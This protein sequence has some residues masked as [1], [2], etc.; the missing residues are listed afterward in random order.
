MTVRSIRIYVKAFRTNLQIKYI[1]S[2]ARTN[3]NYNSGLSITNFNYVRK[4]SDNLV[5]LFRG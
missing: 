3:Q 5:S 1:C 2:D 4:Y